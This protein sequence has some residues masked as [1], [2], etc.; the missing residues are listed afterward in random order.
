MEQKVKKRDRKN[1]IRLMKWRGLEVPNFT[2][3]VAVRENKANEREE[4]VKEIIQENILEVSMSLN[5]REVKVLTFL[6]A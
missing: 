5:G 3:R 6:K 4:V 2:S 1:K